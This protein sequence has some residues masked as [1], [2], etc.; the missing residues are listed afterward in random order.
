ME[1]AQRRWNVTT[2]HVP[3]PF[4]TPQGGGVAVA[5]GAALDQLRHPEPLAD[6][7]H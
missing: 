1:T 3:L 7:Q 5:T 2:G 4:R 6:P